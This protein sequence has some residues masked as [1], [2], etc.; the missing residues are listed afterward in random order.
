MA[1]SD[2]DLVLFGG[3]GDLAMRKLLP[4]M[5][6]R[7][8][9]NDLPDTARIICVGR[10]DWSQEQFVHT[11]ETTS[12]PHIKETVVEE[13]WARFIKRIVYVAV[14]AS[15]VQTYGK[16][17]E[18][19]RADESITRVYY[20]ATPPSL[21]AQICDNLKAT[22]L[23]TPNSRVVLEKPLGRDLASAKRINAEVG[24]VFAE[25]QI[26][27]IDHYLGKETVQN[28]L[29]LRFG[30]ILFE[31]LWRR[32]WISDVQITIAEKIGVGNR[33]GYYDTS[34]ALRDM[35]QNHL[36]QLLCIVAMEPP[37]SIS[38]DAVRD[39]KLQ[40]LRSLKRF[41]PTTLSQNIVRGQY[42]AGYVD[43]KAVPG[44]R[45]EP[46]AP[47]YS[48]TETFVALKAE[49]DTWRWAGVPFYLRTGKRMSDR[50][51]EIVV[52]FKQI[53][54]SIFN[55]PTSSFQPNSLV[56]RLQPDEGLSLNLMA[57]TPGDSM[58]LKQAELELDFREQFKAPRMEAYE[59]LLLDVL[60]G[61]LTLFM[62]GDELE[63][64]WE[65]VEPILDHWDHDDHSPLPYASGTWGPAASSALIG[66]DGLQWREEAL[67]ED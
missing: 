32:E 65:W 49:I 25:S 57:K 15:D 1:L 22:G 54:H 27:R 10:A 26:Y 16:L 14:N 44:Y 43:G 5:Y 19:L 11:V 4:A 17:V 23:A 53:P 67:P 7:D 30:N 33:L 12:R 35:L 47:K 55:Q 29:A 39:S 9:C 38:P 41:T 8:V 3:S 52:R 24:K 51:A 21:F 18:A 62:R 66:R 48:K 63:A 34:G 58:R 2:F 60:R 13:R 56:I 40:V 6:A 31:P 36:L 64:A 59:R 20:L 37:T 45:E 28:L 61:Q 46:D 50:L 42:R